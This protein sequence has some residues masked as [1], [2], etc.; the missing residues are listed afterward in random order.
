MLTWRW[1][2]TQ[3]T[4]E[5]TYLY[6]E[7]LLGV[8]DW[9]GCPEVHV[10]WKIRLW[11]DDAMILAE[12]ELLSELLQPTQPP[13]DGQEGVVVQVE[14]IRLLPVCGGRGEKVFAG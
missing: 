6:L 8:A 4:T 5:F 7:G 11:P 10:E 9:L 12:G 14:D 13:G 1:A 2:H 3:D